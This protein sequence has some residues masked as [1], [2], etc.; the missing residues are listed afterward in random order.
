MAPTTLAGM[1]ATTSPYGRDVQDVGEP[2]KVCELL[3]SLA[4]PVFI[5]RVSLLD[6]PG[7]I[8]AKKAVKK[9]LQYNKEKKGFSLVEMISTCPTNWGKD[10]IESVQWAKEN[11]LPVFPVGPIRDKGAEL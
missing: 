3:D 5:E 7:V 2:I 8:N 6:V 11:M 4:A 9:A 10:A 1:K